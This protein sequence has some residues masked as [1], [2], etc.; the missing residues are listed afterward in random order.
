MYTLKLI[1]PWVFFAALLLVL[2]LSSVAYFTNNHTAKGGLLVDQ[3]SV[4]D[5]KKN[6]DSLGALNVDSIVTTKK[7][8]VK[9]TDEALQL[10]NLEQHPALLEIGVASIETFTYA[11][12]ISA[13][14]FNTAQST[15]QLVKVIE[16]SG[17]VNYAEP[18]YVV[19]VESVDDS[20]GSESTL[21]WALHNTGVAGG[22][23]DADIDAPEA[24]AAFAKHPKSHPNNTPR[25]V[26]AIIDTGIDLAHPALTPHL[27]HYPGAM[28]NRFGASACV[29]DSN[30]PAD[31]NGHGTQVAGVIASLNAHNEFKLLPIKA[32]CA[33]GRGYHSDIIAAVDHLLA[34]KQQGANISVVNLSFG[35]SDNG[36]SLLSA[37]Q[38]LANKNVVIVASA[39]NGSQSNDETPRYPSNYPIAQMIVVAASDHSD[40]LASTTNYGISTV[41]LAAPG[42]DIYTAQL[43]GDY[44]KSSGTSLSAAYISGTAAMTQVVHPSLSAVNIKSRIIA[45]VDKRNQ[46]AGKVASR[47]RLNANN[48]FDTD[49]QLAVDQLNAVDRDKYVQNVARDRAEPVSNS[50]QLD[51]SRAT[52]TLELNIVPNQIMMSF[53]DAFKERS[54]Q[55]KVQLLAPF[56]VKIIKDFPYAG[57][58]VLLEISDAPSADLGKLPVGETKGSVYQQVNNVITQLQESGLVAYAEPDVIFQTSV[59]PNDTRYDELWGLE[60]IQ[61]EQTW[62][63]IE[64]NNPNPAE[65]IIG[66]IDTGVDYNHP[67]L[68][69]NM[70][71]NTGEIAGNGIDDDGNGYVDDVYG[72]D[73]A[74][75]D[76]D[77][78]D[79]HYHGTHV[80]G[81]IGAVRNNSEGVVGVTPYVRVM[82]LKFLDASGSGSSSD[83]IE[84]LNYV[85]L[86]KQEKGVDIKLTNNS[87]GG[88]GYTQ[89]LRD[90]IA[91]S[92]DYDILFVAAAGNSGQDV[93]SFPHYPSSYDVANIISVAATDINDGL[94]SFSNYGS[95]VDVAAPGVSILSTYPNNSY[96]SISGT[97]MAAPHVSGA[98][99]LLFSA[100]PDVD[101]T[102]IKNRLIGSGDVLSSLVGKTI[103]STRLNAYNFTTAPAALFDVDIV[104]GI[105]SVPE[106]SSVTVNVRLKNAPETN[107]PVILTIVKQSGDEDINLTSATTLTFDTLNWTAWQA[108]TFFATED[109]NISDDS[110][111]F[112]LTSINSTPQS[113]AV[114]EQDNKEIPENFCD[115]VSEIPV[116]E[117]E[118]LINFYQDTGGA[119]WSNSSDWLSTATPCS[120]YGVTC[121]SSRVTS[122]DFYSN[123]LVGELPPAIGDFPEL[124]TLVLWVN[125]LSGSIVTELGNLSNLRYLDLAANSFT[126][127]IPSELGSLTQLE[128][129]Y[130]ENNSLS[131]NIPGAI[132]GLTNLRTLWLHSNRFDGQVPD[133]F[134]NLT[135]LSNVT[136]SYN[137]LELDGNDDIVSQLD[138]SSIST[139]TVPPEGVALA[140]SDG[141]LVINWNPIL[142]V[143]NGGEYII[144]SS[145]TIDGIYVEHG[146]TLSKSDSSY[147]IGSE[148]D[149]ANRYFI[150]QSYTPAH[151][152]NPRNDIISQ[153]SETVFYD[154]Q[155]EVLPAVIFPPGAIV[156]EA[157]FSGG[158]EIS[159]TA[160]SQFLSNAQAINTSESIVNNAPS[161]FPIGV[162]NV[163]FSVCN[164]NAE[165]VEAMQTV[166]VEDTTAP[167]INIP[168]NATYEAT[169]LLT[170]I[171]FGNVTALDIVDGY[172]AAVVSPIA[173]YEVGEHSITWVA[174]DAAGNI[175]SATQVITV[176]DTTPPVINV[177]ENIVVEANALLTPVDAGEATATDI[178]DGNLIPSSD[179]LSSYPVGSHVITW[180]IIDSAGL[181]S[182][183]TQT[184][185][186]QDT[187]APV[188]TIPSDVVANAGI[189]FETGAATATDIF[190]VTV[191]SDAPSGVF[192]FGLTTIT[193]T[194]TDTNGNESTAE[195][196]VTFNPY[197]ANHSGQIACE[198]GDDGDTA[199]VVD[200]DNDSVNMVSITKNP[201]TS[202]RVI[203][204]KNDYFIF[205]DSKPSSITRVNNY[206]ATTYA[207]TG[208][209]RFNQMDY[210]WIDGGTVPWT[211]WKI[212]LRNEMPIASVAHDNML[213]VALYASGEIIKIDT[214]TRQIVSRLTV[215][216]K[217]KA[218]ALTS[219]GSRLLVTRFISNA[220][221]GE[222]YDILTAGDM[223]F[224]DEA[225]PSI[226]INKIWVPDDIDHGSG[227]ANYL[228][229]IVIDPKDEFAYVTAN[230]ANTE[231]G[232]YLSGI[233]LSADN[234]IRS[235]V[236]VL[237]LSTHSDTNVDA[238][239]REGTTDVQNSADPSG[240]T[241][242]PDGTT[243]VYALQGSNRIAL[244]DFGSESTLSVNVGS[245]PQSLC[246]TEDNLYVKNY[247]DRTM[248]IIDIKDYI[249]TGNTALTSES[250]VMTAPEHDVL[251]A[252]ELQGLQ[253]FYSANQSELSPEGY[254]SCASC[255]DGG[256]HDGMT[257]DFTHMG[258]GLRNT[259]SLRGTSGTRFGPLNWSASADEV[260]DI[261]KQLEQLHG[262]NGFIPGATFT[263]QSP[264]NH[265]SAGSSVELD[266]LS[267]YVSSLGKHSV[268]KSPNNCAWGDQECWSTYYSGSWQYYSHG[269]KDCHTRDSHSSG[270]FRDGLT[271]DVGTISETS[272]LGS[273]ALLTGIRTP[274]LINLWD[275]AP[276]LHDGSAE[277]LEE[278][279]STGVHATYGL[280]EREMRN[281]IQYLNNIDRSQYIGDDEVFNP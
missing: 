79:D 232:E 259:L 39:G 129:L 154:G 85:H 62:D 183:A 146:R 109:T 251:S 116:S 75:D 276:Y 227:V 210:P 153:A 180:R 212:S 225:Q 27:W 257:W 193:W 161:V 181:E 108:M 60:K 73:A 28:P 164:I 66:V 10:D 70:W 20:Q 246:V 237:D 35:G 23:A 203:E 158:V 119:N 245:A 149:Y 30:S 17:L 122:L 100:E 52:D 198:K 78:M 134:L 2:I 268:L 226:R 82:A 1:K 208:S 214:V 159:N 160:I 61:A 171:D 8:L 45:G 36:V 230:K 12:N 104:G 168:P 32:L 38:Q 221:Y 136:A 156:V 71:V 195:Q 59:V 7:I 67:D 163:V 216:P 141:N 277:T 173:L 3:A 219:D 26:V 50:S 176:Q 271:H 103:S 256:G 248:S 223:S 279:M 184:I 150:V 123:N 18:D 16:Q 44:D 90:A 105:V 111:V 215:G 140:V 84:L 74:N 249:S 42:V 21:P 22:V 185:T 56:G 144:S 83:A 47:G 182:I 250:I 68:A 267:D 29:N 115:I 280:D 209:I 202:E 220:D 58:S 172:V 117:C 14:A 231:R 189:A 213:Y 247:T 218:M 165:C 145:D 11:G 243:G 200:E 264:L 169:G 126:G 186:V 199:W 240:L 206:I 142:Y 130:T 138:S 55:E 6:E 31:A 48:I 258:E 262:S 162:T 238:L 96:N 93:D 128:V 133:N 269:C 281:L 98:I 152:S 177:P 252:T 80:A 270:T 106:G 175:G 95:S 41:D 166:T 278:V 87:W 124:Q 151:S 118:A 13:L 110:A 132:G 37:L 131:G 191:S 72:W 148:S 241:A 194:A 76:G 254:M 242:L 54:L 101:I 275:T 69:D 266:A 253:L 113:I 217:P 4:Q 112:Q 77:P 24:W 64:Q 272:G 188:L 91:A 265:M 233:A 40:Q 174:V 34:L 274:T 43:N 170:G 178:V 263:E 53:S 57:G 196:S 65:V 135:S 92:N 260:Q 99:G 207:D 224:R 5:T 179:Q 255:H 33:D 107:E 114:Q 273:G 94:A 86:M 46:F 89:S 9:F 81:T 244:Y 88:G 63:Y 197:Y 51:R 167:S 234:T 236:A 139:Q 147:V 49:N 190:P 137:A 155:L 192:P 229:S 25:P 97:S 120:W 205:T 261:E 222:V 201:I 211:T 143:E 15:E 187:T 239:T 228:R 235:M 204:T 157:T 127:S 125:Q 102:D 19:S 121:Q